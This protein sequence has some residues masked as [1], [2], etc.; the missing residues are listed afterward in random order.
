M[1]FSPNIE[2]F[3]YDKKSISSKDINI[4]NSKLSNKSLL[5]I[6]ELLGDNMKANAAKPHTNRHVDRY[7]DLTDIDEIKM[8]PNPL[9]VSN[10]RAILSDASNDDDRMMVIE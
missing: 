6:D 9:K 1:Q 4:K 10:L 7:D 3:N 5:D 2:Y 8:L